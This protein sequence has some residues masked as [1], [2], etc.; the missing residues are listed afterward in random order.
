MKTCLSSSGGG[1][2]DSLIIFIHLCHFSIVVIAFAD[3]RMALD[4]VSFFILVCDLVVSIVSEER[5][6]HQLTDLLRNVA[7]SHLLRIDAIPVGC[8]NFGARED[9][10]VSRLTSQR[11]PRSS[12]PAQQRQVQV[13]SQ[14]QQ[15]FASSTRLLKHPSPV[16]GRPPHSGHPHL[17]SR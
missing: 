4:G 16:A 10:G 2:F 7:T 1:H 15:P 17:L 8:V 6:S 13:S 14:V 11:D 3:F 9:V 12:I 5:V